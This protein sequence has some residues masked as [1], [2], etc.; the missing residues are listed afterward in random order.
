MAG[1]ALADHER[2]WR[3]SLRDPA[4]QTLIVGVQN[5]DGPALVAFADA[6]PAENSGATYENYIR[7]HD[8]LEP[9]P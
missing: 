7:N 5:A 1:L 8:A 6:F 2:Q 3:A 4:R 9:R